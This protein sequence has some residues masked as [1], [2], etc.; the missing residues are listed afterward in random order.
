MEHKLIGDNMQALVLTMAK[1]EVVMSE[2]GSMLYFRGG[3]EFDTKTSGGLFKSIKRSL[4]TG[5]SLFMTYFRC[6]G[7][8]GEVAMAAPVPG[9]IHKV[10]LAGNEV[11]CNKDAFLCSYGEVNVDI[12]FTKKFKAGL[13]GGEGFI[14]QKLS[15]NGTSFITSGGNFVE[16][17]L[18]QGEVLMVDT[19]CLVMM[20]SS[21]SYDVQMI[22][23]VKKFLFGGE[24]LFLVKL[25]GPGKVVLQTLPFSRLA[26]EMGNH[27]VGQGGPA[28]GALGSIFR[29]N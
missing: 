11:L 5:E 9:K 16:M 27:Y 2:S 6:T 8:Y 7:D 18:Q 13:F 20:D 21:V 22:G 28:G 14:L 1:D 12:A 26:Q 10:D 15:G 4:F 19:G 17:E 24:G 23:G 25:T 29:N 3:I